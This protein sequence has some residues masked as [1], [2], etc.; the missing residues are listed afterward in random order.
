MMAPWVYIAQA[1]LSN[2]WHQF[3]GGVRVWIQRVD[4]GIGTEAAKSSREKIG[5]YIAKFDQHTLIPNHNILLSAMISGSYSY[6]R[7]F[8]YHDIFVALFRPKSPS[9]E[10]PTRQGVIKWR[11]VGRFEFD[12][13]QM[14]YELSL[15][16]YCGFLGLIS[17]ILDGPSEPG[18]ST[19]LPQSC[20]YRLAYRTLALAGNGKWQALACSYAL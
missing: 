2:K 7:V 10:A 3:G 9:V 5:N 6:S 15:G 11:W 14:G 19:P 4:A 8:S 13:I 20:P 17:Q 18:L 16:L 12:D 1:K